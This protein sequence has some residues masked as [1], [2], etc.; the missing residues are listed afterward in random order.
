MF[1]CFIT[2][3]HYYGFG[4]HS[5]VAILSD[6]I[7]EFIRNYNLQVCMTRNNHTYNPISVKEAVED[8]KFY[9]N[10]PCDYV[11]DKFFVHSLDRDVII[12]FKMTF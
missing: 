7:I 3:N 9:I 5:K 11:I 1:K 12:L 8:H 6:E 2:S 10:G 4:S